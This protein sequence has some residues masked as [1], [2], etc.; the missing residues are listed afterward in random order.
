MTIATLP[1]DRPSPFGIST[2][3]Y[4]IVDVHYILFDISVPKMV[5]NMI[6]E[7]KAR[8]SRGKR[9]SSWFVTGTDGW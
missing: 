6:D 8:K 5:P 1:E 7:N 4:E 9:S 2:H 3:A